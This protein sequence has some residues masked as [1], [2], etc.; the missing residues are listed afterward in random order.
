MSAES[1]RARLAERV[2]ALVGAVLPGAAFLDL[3]SPLGPQ[4]V[5]FAAYDEDDP[6]SAAELAAALEEALRADGWR[7]SASCDGETEGLNVA[8]EGLGGGAFGV[9]TTVVTFMGLARPPAGPPP[10]APLAAL[11]AEVRAAIQAATPHPVHPRDDFADPAALRI[12][13]WDPDEQQPNEALLDKAA[14]YLA[15][16]GWQVGPEPTD[17]EDRSARVTKPGLAT[18]RLQASNHALTFTGHLTP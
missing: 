9:Q 4:A 11:S 16:H 14:A 5:S 6:R 10:A 15:A 2:T 1:D 3:D 13:G 12:A 7:T 18:G 8:Q 17:S